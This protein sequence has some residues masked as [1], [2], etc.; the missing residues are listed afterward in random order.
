MIAGPPSIP[1]V[2]FADWTSDSSLKQKRAI[3]QKLIEACRTVGFV[4]ITNHHLPSERL[5][6]AFQWSKK[7]FDL[8]LEQKMLAPHPSGFTVH[9]GYSWPGLEK[10]SNAMGDEDDKAEL[11]KNL[12]QVSDV[13]VRLKMYPS[14]PNLTGRMFT[15][16]RKVM[17]SAAKRIKTNQI[18]GFL[19]IFFRASANS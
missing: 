12:R 6:Q 11:T 17:K 5:A 15:A 3:A 19:T 13:K 9:R 8:K 2:D 16:S 1:V 18:N 4:Y 7:L 10:V 14:Y